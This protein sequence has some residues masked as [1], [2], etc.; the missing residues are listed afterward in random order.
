VV[1]VARPCGGGARG[2]ARALEGRRF[3]VGVAS[4]MAEAM[5]VKGMCH[6]HW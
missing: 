6:E 4:E 2:E 1:R 3:L 5:N